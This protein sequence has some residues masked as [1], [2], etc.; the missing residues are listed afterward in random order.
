ME[1]Q[2]GDADSLWEC[3]SHG[4]PGKGNHQMQIYS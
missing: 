4:P 3:G 1:R 2:G